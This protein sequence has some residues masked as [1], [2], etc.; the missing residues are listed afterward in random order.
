[1]VRS[2]GQV[3]IPGRDGDLADAE[4][5]AEA[6][7]SQLGPGQLGIPGAAQSFHGR[8]AGGTGKRGRVVTAQR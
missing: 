7:A 6:P 1:M 8:T 3:A 2:I 4:A 5:G